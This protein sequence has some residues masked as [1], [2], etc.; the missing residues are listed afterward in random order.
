MSK[1]ADAPKPYLTDR[2]YHLRVEI[3]ILF[4]EAQRL[5]SKG[6]RRRRT[7]ETAEST[8]TPFHWI[9]M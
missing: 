4:A 7:T 5:G 2:E 1:G 3:L 8:R 6:R 9:V